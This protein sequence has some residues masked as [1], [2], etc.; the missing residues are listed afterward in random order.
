MYVFL[1]FSWKMSKA[2]SNIGCFKI[3]CVIPTQGYDII[4][5]PY[6]FSVY[7]LREHNWF[8]CRIVRCL[9]SSN[10]LIY[11]INFQWE[12]E[13]A[14]KYLATNP[15]H[16]PI[17]CHQPFPLQYLLRKILCCTVEKICSRLNLQ[18]VICHEK[19][20]KNN[21]ARWI[22]LPSQTELVLHSFLNY[23]TYLLKL[24]EEFF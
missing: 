20:H 5:F 16:S 15:S 13:N 2:Y 6:H 7:V 4:L 23:A 12:E 22:A 24:P 21:S 14:A 9:R 10:T 11:F 19:H 17:C 8:N 3:I 1:Q 18:S